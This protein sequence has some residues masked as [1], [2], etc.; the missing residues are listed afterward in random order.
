M[1]KVL[2]L[3]IET[4]PSMCYSWRMWKANISQDMIVEGGYMLSCSMKWLGNDEV[5]YYENRTTDDR[6]LVDI[7]IDYLDKADYVIA[8]NGESFDIP[9]IKYRAVVH[10]IKP[11][12]P[13]KIIDTLRI[14]RKEFLF[15]RNTLA[16]LAKELGVSEKE[17]HAEFAGFKLWAECLKDNPKAWKV[18]RHYNIQDVITLEQ[19]YLQLRP[20]AKEHPNVTVEQEDT[21]GFRCPK[22]GSIHIQLRGY[23]FTN[24]SKYHKYVCKDCGGWSRTRYTTNS[25]EQRRLLL[26]SA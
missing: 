22:C 26:R 17:E 16:N 7:V 5:F 1:S 2:I 8:H 13:F 14:A 4:A 23:S 20:W 10:G 12:S 9:Y 21:S 25:I 3:D 6:E 15:S 18:M 19:V 11:P 24:S